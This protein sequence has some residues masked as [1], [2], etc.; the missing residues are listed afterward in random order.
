MK[1][2]AILVSFAAFVLWALAMWLGSK[3]SGFGDGFPGNGPKLG[4]VLVDYFPIGYFAF[5]LGG[6]FAPRA[7]KRWIVVAVVAQLLIV[8]CLVEMLV[9]SAE[10]FLGLSLLAYICFWWT[11]FSKS[12]REIRKEA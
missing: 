9:Y 6:S 7:T 8:P 11:A 1:K 2:A 3:L 4:H 5:C 10:Y 12:P